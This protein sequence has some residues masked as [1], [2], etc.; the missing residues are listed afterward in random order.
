MAWQYVTVGK[1]ALMDKIL[2]SMYPVMTP[3]GKLKKNMDLKESCKLNGITSQTLYNWM[4]ADNSLKLA[5]DSAQETQKEVMTIKA[6]ENVFKAIDWEMGLR[7]REIVDVSFRFLEKTNK[8][9]QPTSNIEL[10]STNMNFDISLEELNA[11]I[12]SLQDN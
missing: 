2:L 12:K 8:E 9:F 3:E 11:K 5:W 4:R 6:K 1:R 10:K 7:K